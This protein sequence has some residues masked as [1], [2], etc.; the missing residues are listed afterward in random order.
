MRRFGGFVAI[1]GLVACVWLLVACESEAPRFETELAPVHTEL[2]YLKDA[3]GRY[4][5]LR[6]TNVGGS[7]KVPVFNMIDVPIGK[8]RGFTYVG[9]PFAPGEEEKWFGQLKDLGFNAI[10]LLFIWEAVFPDE[11]GVPDEEFLDYFENLI[12]LAGE[13]GIY[14]VLNM[15]ENLWSRHL[16][17]NYNE[18][19]KSNCDPD[20]GLCLDDVI[21]PLF[22][23]YT[24][25]VKG[26]GAPL[27]ATKACLPEKNFESPNWGMYHVLGRINDPIASYGLKELAKTLKT[28]FGMDIDALV[29]TMKE[30]APDPFPVTD[31][32]DF[33][34]WTFWG[35][36]AAVSL[37]VERCYAALFAGDLVYPNHQVVLTK[38]G[39][40]VV[41]IL[42]Q[43]TPNP[44]A[45]VIAD[46]DIERTWT[47][48]S[49]LQEGFT[50]AW[51]EV[52][53]RAVKYPNV[54]G[55]DVMN[56]PTSIFIL[57]TAAKAYFDLGLDGAV[58]DLLHGLF[59]D[60]EDPDK[61][62]SG[63]DIWT[64][65][66]LLELL[67][68]VHLAKQGLYN[69]T[70]EEIMRDWGFEGADLLA[71]AGLN[72]G[73]GQNHLTPLFEKVGAEINQVYLDT[74]GDEFAD[75]KPIIYL[76]PA[77]SPDML[78]SSGGGLG[79]QWQSYQIL[80]RFA[81]KYQPVQMVWS[82]HWY[83]DIYPFLGFNQ[84]PR[85]FAEYEYT[86]RDWTSV[87]QGKMDVARDTFDNI[88]TVFG[89][90][91]TYWNYRYEV[92]EPPSEANDN[93]PAY[94]G[95]CAVYDEDNPR[96]ETDPHTY[97]GD[98][99]ERPGY[100]QSRYFDYKTSA[101]IMDNYY[102]SFEKLFMSN[103]NWC[104]TT[105]ND[106]VYGDWWN[107]ED[108]SIID[109]NG[110]PRGAMAWVRPYP[111]AISG[112]PVS[113]HFYSDYHYYD[114]TKGEPDPQREFE[115]VFESKET[116]APTIIFVPNIQ[117]PDGFYVWLSDGWVAWNAADQ[118][119]YVYPTRDEP[120]WQHKVVIRPP[121][122]G[123]DI[124]GWSYY[125]EGQQVIAGHGQ[126][127]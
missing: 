23:P 101:E 37:D 46:D 8:Q 121:V 19:V 82:P 53:K 40:T 3:Q 43:E 89:E 31:T 26:D 110:E 11:K 91:G 15:H 85:Q 29:E 83:P 36:N 50:E 13:H 122:A 25:S 113:M 55:Y 45:P 4:V 119:L 95:T 39:R 24:D 56:E 76:E 5:H 126:S 35:T 75:R 86:H 73:F 107:H 116:D 104:Y 28:D 100:E 80:P 52:T 69:K 71:M 106:P 44:D 22:P 125:I 57:L 60:P 87:L 63:D 62:N 93:N 92:C 124:S 42:N 41:R 65:I 108:F 9:R 72:I 1:A 49:Y 79:G 12:R 112:K 78:L 32:T 68:P 103:I 17:A 58:G 88:P 123:R 99:F 54:I 96:P 30:K 81:E 105:D 16:F 67:P 6:G 27:W 120:K 51:V 61:S 118:L 94:T 47:L 10:R 64:L 115:L 109:E 20:G 33:L 2:T 102:E 90:F 127:L 14:V 77:F 59:L 38:D 34:P 70:P 114:P 98:D 18:D 97:S 84:K 74:Y 7:T 21:L 111:R 48:E 66:G 117:Y